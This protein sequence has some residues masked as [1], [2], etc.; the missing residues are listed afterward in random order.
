MQFTLYATIIV[1][2]ACTLF[3]QDAG[4]GGAQG[5]GG[6]QGR[7]GT[8]PAAGMTL[9]I[10]GFPDGGQIPAKFSAGAQGADAISPAMTW[11]GAPAGTQSFVLHM[12]DTNSAS[13]KTLNDT[14]HWLIWNLPATVTSLPEGVPKG[15]QMADG[16][17]QISNSGPVYRGPGA[18]ANGPFHHYVIELYALDSKID[19]QPSDDAFETRAKVMEAI[20]GHIVGKAVYFGQFRRSQ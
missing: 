14:V 10:P 18:G 11:T 8:G 2:S 4:R 7:A 12:H 5:R 13:N 16:S 15:S 20:Q 17:Y 6:G 3:A 1:A 9:T 19:V